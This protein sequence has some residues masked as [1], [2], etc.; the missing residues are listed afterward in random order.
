MENR[1]LLCD[2]IL[3]VTIHICKCKNMEAEF[4]IS[5]VMV[6]EKNECLLEIEALKNNIHDEFPFL[7]YRDVIM[8]AVASQ[9]SSVLL[10]C[11][12]VCSNAYKK[13]HQSFASLAFVRGIHRCPVDSLHKGPVTWKKLPFDDVIMGI[14]S[15]YLMPIE[16]VPRNYGSPWANGGPRAPSPP[17]PPP[18]PPWSSWVVPF[19]QGT[20]RN[21]ISDVT[22][23]KNGTHN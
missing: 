13:K 9:I 2:Y 22:R 7:Y 20:L 3:I 16:S 18:P 4:V 14:Q 5:L 12:T 6:S 10:V 15:E 23:K 1:F 17:P 11:S 21:H 19:F 8:S